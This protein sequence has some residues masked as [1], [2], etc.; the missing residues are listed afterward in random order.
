MLLSAL[1]LAAGNLRLPGESGV[2]LQNREGAGGVSVL[3]VLLL[4]MMLGRGDHRGEESTD[5]ESLM[6]PGQGQWDCFPLALAQGCGGTAFP[7]SAETPHNPGV[8]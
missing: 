3:W 6:H 7:G 2:L 4:D 8:L 5:I 1:D